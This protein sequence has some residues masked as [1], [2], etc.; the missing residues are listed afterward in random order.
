MNPREE[1][2][3]LLD[4]LATQRDELIVQAHLARLEAEGE[5]SELEAKLDLLRGK[6]AQAAEVAEDAAG[7]V[8]A[9]ARLLGEEIAKGYERLRRLF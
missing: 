1:L 6:A 5:W 9:A 2:Q 7:D 4:G 3:K 8:A